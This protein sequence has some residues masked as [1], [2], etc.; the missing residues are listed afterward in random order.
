MESL[1]PAGGAGSDEDENRCDSADDSERTISQ[2]PSETPIFSRMRSVSI[3]LLK[4]FNCGACLGYTG[5]V[6]AKVTAFDAVYDAEDEAR[7]IS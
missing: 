1:P 7:R 6:F 3:L 4:L 2:N 5:G